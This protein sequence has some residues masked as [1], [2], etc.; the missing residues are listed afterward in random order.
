[1]DASCRGVPVIYSITHDILGDPFWAV[2]NRGVLDAADRHDC[3]LHILRPETY[4]AG[5][6]REVIERAVRARPDGLLCTIPDGAALEQP[7]RSAAEKGIALIAANARDQRVNGERIPYLLY[8]GGDDR[9]GGVLA[10]RRLRES[11]PARN[12]VCFDHYLTEQSCHADR[13]IGLA[14]SIASAGGSCRRFRIP[15]HDPH[16]ASLTLRGVLESDRDVDGIVTLG[17]PG[18]K[19]VFDSGPDFKNIPHVSFDLSREQLSALAE[20]RLLAIVDSQQYLQGFLG[21]HLL[22]LY[23][24]AGLLPSG[25]IFTGPAI[26]DAGN[27]ENAERAFATGMR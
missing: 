24:R 7:L 19:A 11:G 27:L 2:Y 8:V 5:N 15:G 4:S 10:G 12:V 13:F 26:V 25:D 21:I 14:E 3:D 18:A 22:A 16:A 23:L 6:M 9:A 1:M 20:H 17:P